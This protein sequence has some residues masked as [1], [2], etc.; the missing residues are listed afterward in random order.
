[1]LSE[2]G[3]IARTSA[4]PVLGERTGRAVSASGGRAQAKAGAVEQKPLLW[5]A[6]APQL[7]CR[8]QKGATL[9]LQRDPGA[10]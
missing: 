2:S 5:A 6:Q 10:I 3:D 1:M 7:R 4:H 8:Q 9:A